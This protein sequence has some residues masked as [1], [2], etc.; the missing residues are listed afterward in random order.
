MLTIQGRHSYIP[1]TEGNAEDCSRY[2]DKV[3]TPDSQDSC[4]PVLLGRTVA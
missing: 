3:S 2:K 4:L 1:L